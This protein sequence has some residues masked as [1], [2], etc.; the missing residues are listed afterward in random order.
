MSKASIEIKCTLHSLEAYVAFL[1]FADTWGVTDTD[2]RPVVSNGADLQLPLPKGLPK[3]KVK[4]RN[5]GRR[6][7]T[8]SPRLMVRVTEKFPLHKSDLYTQ[9]RSELLALGPMP[10]ARLAHHVAKLGSMRDSGQP[11]KTVSLWISE[12]AVEVLPDQ[13]V[14]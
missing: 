10:R 3:P 12:G 1:A 13:K 9:H 5:N 2:V 7:A 14:A 8:S 11:S 4:H 6:Y